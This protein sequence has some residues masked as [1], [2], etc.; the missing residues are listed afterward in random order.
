MFCN[1]V[2]SCRVRNLG[3]V[4]VLIVL[5][6]TF[7]LGIT[8]IAV[9]GGLMLSRKQFVQASAD[10]AALAAAS[11]ILGGWT[12][13]FDS[14]GKARQAAM[15]CIDVNNRWGDGLIIDWDKMTVRTSPQP[16]VKAS[17]EIT[18]DE[19]HLR[20]GYVEVIVA[21]N[22]ER[23]FSAIFGSKNTVPIQARAVA[24]GRYRKDRDGILVLDRDDPRALHVHGVGG[25]IT[26]NVTGEDAEIIVNSSVT[27]SPGAASAAGGATV[28][29]PGMTVTGAENASGGGSFQ[30]TTPLVRGAPPTADPLRALPEPDP[31]LLGLATIPGNGK[32]VA[33]PN[34]NNVITLQPGVYPFG[35]EMNGNSGPL[36]VTMSPGVYYIQD[37]GFSTSGQ[38]NVVGN[39]VM[40]YN[41]SPPSTNP[42][43]STGFSVS[44]GSTLNLT[45]LESWSSSAAKYNGIVIFA[46]RDTG[47]PISLSGG[48]GTNIVGTIYAPNSPTMVTGNG[49]AVMGSRYIC[50]TLDVGGTGTM[51]VVYDPKGHPR[52]RILQLVQ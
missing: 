14:N 15:E 12:D 29:A 36:S 27:E 10:S 48:S 1:Q 4:L 26:L 20:E 38:V 34:E 18:D 47:S 33:N 8:A 40:I 19:G 50:R 16:P 21:Y 11:T 37:G 31:V 17:P 46:D 43:Q 22:Q 7:L 9:D 45:P 6:L 23:Y 30:L 13:G 39:G 3:S 32:Y 49:N 2:R 44:G 5:C 41:G 51:S 52:D 28:V 35:I 42:G 25:N 24:R